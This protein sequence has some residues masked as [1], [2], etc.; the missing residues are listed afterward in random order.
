MKFYSELTK[1]VYN[2]EDELLDAENKFKTEEEAAAA[3]ADEAKREREEMKKL[4][5]EK[6]RIAAEACDEYFK[7]K[8]EFEKKF[9]KKK[10]AL[11]IL[12]DILLDI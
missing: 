3:K 6:E 8:A 12:V 2:T 7:V 10:D 9:P 5:K 11:D 4:L 1:K